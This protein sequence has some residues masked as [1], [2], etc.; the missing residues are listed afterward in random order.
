MERERAGERK[1]RGGGKADLVAWAGD[2][3]QSEGHPVGQPPLHDGVAVAGH[4]QGEQQDGE[5]SLRQQTAQS[6]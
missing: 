4:Q 1:A 6:D 5:L 3:R 2:P